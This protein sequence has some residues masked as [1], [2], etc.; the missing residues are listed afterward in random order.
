MD[1][2]NKIAALYVATLKCMALIHQ[3]NHWTTK[4]SN[5]YGDHL[6]FKRLYESASEDLDL[7]AEKFIGVLGEEIMN[8]DFQTELVNKILSKYSNLE[9]SP[10]EMSMEVEKDFITFSASAYECLK[11]EGKMTLGLD[12]M[13]MA[14]ASKREE[15]VYLLKQALNGK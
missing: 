4:G 8:Y 2:C 7:A 15:S 13:I 10:K 5:F 1:K 9:G 3:H 6:L 12:D 11:K 14:I